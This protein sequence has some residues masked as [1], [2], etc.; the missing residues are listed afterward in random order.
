[1]SLLLF[2]VFGFVVGLL[3]RAV[4]PGRQS[5]GLLMTTVL[6]VVGSFIGGF[7]GNLIGGRPVFDMH[8]SGIIGSLVG[9]LIVLAIV[10]GAGRRRVSV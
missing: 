2:L 1:M 9:A 3:A 7:L 8:A 4:M 10:G 5:M 6:G